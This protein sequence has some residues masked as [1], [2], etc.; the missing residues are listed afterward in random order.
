M[1]RVLV[2]VYS[3]NVLLKTLVL[4]NWWLEIRS[5]LRLA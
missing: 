1:E 4:V 2:V 3:L 5:S